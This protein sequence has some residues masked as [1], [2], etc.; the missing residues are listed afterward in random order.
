MGSDVVLDF[1]F[2]SRRTRDDY[3]RLLAPTGAIPETIYLA[4]DRATVL[5]RVRAR[6]GSH[7]DDSVLTD[8]LAAH[9]WSSTRSATSPSSTRRR[10]CLPT[11]LF[12][13]GRA[14]LILTSNKEFG[15]WGEVF[16]D[17]TVAMIDR[18]VHHADVI[19]LKGD[20]YRLE[21][22]DLGRIPTPV[23]TK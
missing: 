9:C 12:P 8:G 18:L 2:W 11:R 1:S 13:L 23:D 10:I 20:S 17:D 4:T 7:P 19:A 14:S 22:H 21:N 5:D 3:R 16:G 15:R 6:R